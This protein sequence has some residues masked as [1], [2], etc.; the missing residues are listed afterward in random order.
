[1]TVTGSR[2]QRAKSQAGCRVKVKILSEEME[3][4]PYTVE[5]AASH[6]APAVS[7]GRPRAELAGS[8]AP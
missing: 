5:R 2:Q 6:A 4:A 3:T 7:P 8:G 1:M